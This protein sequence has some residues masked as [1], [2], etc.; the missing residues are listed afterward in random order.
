MGFWVRCQVNGAILTQDNFLFLVVPASLIDRQLIYKLTKKWIFI[1][2]TTLIWFDAWTFAIKK[3]VDT[4][5][6]FF[7][8]FWIVKKHDVLFYRPLNWMFDLTFTTFYC[9]TDLATELIRYLH[10][11]LL[12]NV[13]RHAS[14]RQMLN[15]HIH[16]ISCPARRLV[17]L[18]AKLEIIRPINLHI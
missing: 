13:K 14:I 5:T 8:T 17:T 2:M 4:K 16:G 7:Y 12:C 18:C 1:N 6:L 10:K 15:L 11:I 3:Q 9:L